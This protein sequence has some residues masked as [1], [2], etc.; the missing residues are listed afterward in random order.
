M[1][2]CA[3]ETS[4]KQ[5]IAAAALLG[6]LEAYTYDCCQVFECEAAPEIVIRIAFGSRWDDGERSRDAP[7]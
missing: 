1:G 7:L 6:A 5:A 2:R 3:Q 4:L